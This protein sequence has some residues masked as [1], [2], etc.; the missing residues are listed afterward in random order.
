MG[1][2]MPKSIS[3]PRIRFTGKSESN[4][5]VSEANEKDPYY[6]SDRQSFSTLEALVRT[7]EATPVTFKDYK[8]PFIAIQGGL[9]K[10]VSPEGVFACLISH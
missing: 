3:Y 10:V 5:T 2:V 1:A 7:I 8:S 9:D 6:L 4:P